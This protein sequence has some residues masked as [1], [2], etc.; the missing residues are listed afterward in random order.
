MTAISRKYGHFQVWTMG[1]QNASTIAD[2]QW[3]LQLDV[4]ILQ[5]P[6]QYRA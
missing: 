6:A 3:L 1:G 4:L 5:N 2:T